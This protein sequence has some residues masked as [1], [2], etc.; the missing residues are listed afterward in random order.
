MR[1]FVNMTEMIAI[2]TQQTRLS[3]Q[4]NMLFQKEKI[5]FLEN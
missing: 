2:G 3:Q 5:Q 4:L 1:F